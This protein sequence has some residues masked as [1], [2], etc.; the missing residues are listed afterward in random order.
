ML[1]RRDTAMVDIMSLNAGVDQHGKFHFLYIKFYSYICVVKNGIL[2]RER[3][4]TSM[5]AIQMS[6]DNSLSL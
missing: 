5:K 6:V 2:L 3:W 1:L 4:C